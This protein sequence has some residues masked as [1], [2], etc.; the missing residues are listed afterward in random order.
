MILDMGETPGLKMNKD[1]AN[2]DETEDTAPTGLRGYIYEKRMILIL[3]TV[4]GCIG[5]YY[6]QIFFPELP[7]YKA[8]IAGMGFGIFCT[9]VALGRHFI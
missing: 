1:S 9:M 2:T 6:A 7:T 5:M 4:F 3:S 8:L